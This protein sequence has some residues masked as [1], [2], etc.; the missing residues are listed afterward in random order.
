MSISPPLLFK[1]TG[2]VVITVS[3]SVGGQRVKGAWQDAAPTETEI[4]AN[5]QPVL[6]S[7]DTLFLPEG[8]RSKVAVKLFTTDELQSRREGSNPVQGD[9]FIWNGYTY[10]VRR[11]ISWQ[12]GFLDHY[13]S[14][15]V[16]REI[17]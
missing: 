14:I 17:T 6:S 10:E 3:R 8:D 13:Q 16:R 11:V 1:L 15:A 4:K 12:M 9:T 5:I 2:Q 7:T